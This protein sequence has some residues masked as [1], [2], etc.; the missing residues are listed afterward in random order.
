MAV[1]NREA[2]RVLDVVARDH[3]APMVRRIHAA[4]LLCGCDDD[5]CDER[6]EVMSSDP[7]LA[8]LAAEM[9]RPRSA[10]PK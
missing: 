8:D 9:F 2:E 1:F 10:P 6:R 7:E 3:A 4:Y 5:A